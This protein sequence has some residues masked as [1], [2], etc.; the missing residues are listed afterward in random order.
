MKAGNKCCRCTK[1]RTTNG[2]LPKRWDLSDIMRNKINL[3]NKHS[4]SAYFMPGLVLEP[5]DRK[6]NLVSRLPLRSSWANGEEY[7]VQ[8]QHQERTENESSGGKDREER[9]NILRMSLFLPVFSFLYT[10]TSSF[11]LPSLVC[12]IYSLSSQSCLDHKWT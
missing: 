4:L 8:W 7:N 9:I 1:N 3:L 6:T 11:P 2:S 10:L 12:H 5:E